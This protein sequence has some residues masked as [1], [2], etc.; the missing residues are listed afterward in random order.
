MSVCNNH[1]TKDVVLGCLFFTS[2]LQLQ[3]GQQK[4]VPIPVLP[5]EQ[6]KVTITIQGD[7]AIGTYTLSKSVTVTVS[8]GDG[9]ANGNCFVYLPISFWYSGF[10]VTD[11]WYNEHLQHAV[12]D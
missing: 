10:V 4:R 8:H 3:R 2:R 12:P 5:T 1:A 11:G 7:S 9:Q 6:G